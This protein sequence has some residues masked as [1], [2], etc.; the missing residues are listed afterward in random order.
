M[1]PVLH[2]KAGLF[3]M[4]NFQP[5]CINQC[6]SL[7]IFVCRNKAVNTLLDYCLAQQLAKEESG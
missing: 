3:V 2:K 5:I 6:S 4:Q 7:I 1:L